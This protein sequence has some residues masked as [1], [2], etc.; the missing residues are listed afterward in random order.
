MYENN[1]KDIELAQQG[2]KKALENLILNNSG[3]IWSIVKRFN[4]RRL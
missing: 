3:L 1:R 2:D 4:G